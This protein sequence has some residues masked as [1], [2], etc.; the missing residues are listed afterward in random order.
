MSLIDQFQSVF[1]SASKPV[2]RPTPRRFEKVLLLTDLPTAEANA[3]AERAHALVAK[4]RGMGKAPWVIT[5]VD[6]APSVGDL[7]ALIER[8]QPD[9][10]V[11]YRNLHSTGWQWPYTLGDH[12]VVLTQVTD[13]PVLL[14]P[15]PDALDPSRGTDSVMAV[16]DHLAGDA[17]LVDAGIAFTAPNGTLYLSHVEDDAIYARYIEMIGKIPNLPTDVAQVELRARMLKEPA[18]YI[19]SVQTALANVDLTVQAEVQ[20]GHHLSTYRQLVQ[21]HGVDLL[22]LNT[23]DDDQLAMHGLAYPLAVELRDVPLLML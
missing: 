18:D 5:D 11:A 22:V 1:R 21:K 2:Y 19:A 6:A 14:L 4:A 17:R 10:V 3:Y 15:R 7:L 9:L 13:V 23:K 16:T 12:V 8:E 20:M